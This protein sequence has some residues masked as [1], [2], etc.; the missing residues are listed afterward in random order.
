M[1]GA[2]LGAVTGLGSILGGG[3]KGAAAERQNQNDFIQRE[4]QMRLQQQ[5]AQQQAL[6]SL[7][8]LDERATMDRAQL[9]IQA[10]S[11]RAKQAV[12]GS[13][14]ARMT[15]AQ[16]T[17]PAGVNMAKISGG[18]A[19]ALGNPQMQA[20]GNALSAQALQALLSKSDVPAA[21]NYRQQ[22]M[23]APAQM[24]PYKS[25]GKGESLMS[26]LGLGGGIAGILGG[27]K[28]K[29]PVSDYPGQ[30]GGG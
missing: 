24:A 30:Y 22:G 17:P 18:A 8:G 28:K 9:G 26:A 20:A 15:P 25:A 16:V 27:L 4:N 5:A 23:V 7:L 14:L 6:L 12:I 19:G 29:P 10:P 13:L 11:A 3:G 1:L 21:A 2:I